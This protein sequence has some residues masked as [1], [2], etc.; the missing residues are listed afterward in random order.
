MKIPTQGGTPAQIAEGN[1][2]FINLTWGADDRIR[3]PSLQ[4]RR[5]PIGL[6]QRR[7]GGHDLVRSSRVCDPCR[8]TAERPFAPVDDDRRRKPDRRARAGWHAAQTAHGL[9]RQ[10]HADRTS[11]VLAS[12]GRG[13]VHRCRAVRCDDGQRHRRGHGAVAR[14]PSA[15]CHARGR[16]CGGGRVLYCRLATLGPSSRDRGPLGGRTRHPG[17]A[18]RL[19]LADRVTRRSSPGARP[20]GRRSTNPLD[21]DARH[22]RLDA[23]DLRR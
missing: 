9:G 14:C 13:M 16:E 22:W 8:G 6:S 15:L 23:G 3:Y 12:G 10:T 21:A 19:A 5:D 1:D 4:Q 18:R 2:Y 11:A 17:A 7:T 20:L